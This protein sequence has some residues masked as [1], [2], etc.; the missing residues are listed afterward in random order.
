M[1]GNQVRFRIDIIELMRGFAAAAIVAFHY[2]DKFD[3]YFT[4]S[5]RELAW[6]GVDIF[7]VIS[8]FIIP[9]S[10]S[11]T[12]YSIARFWHFMGRRMIRLE[13]PYLAS[14]LLILML[15]VINMWVGLVPDADLPTWQQLLS[16]LLYLAPLFGHEWIN[17]VYWTLGCEFL[18]YLLVGLTY[19]HF[20]QSSVV[21]LL[22]FS[23]ACTFVV[24]LFYDKFNVIP[25][26]FLVGVLVYRIATGYGEVILTRLGIAASLLAIASFRVDLMVMVAVT[27]LAILKLRRVR[28]PCWMTIA[29]PLTYSLYLIHAP[30]GNGLLKVAG[31]FGS[32]IW[33]DILIAAATVILVTIITVF[34]YRIFEEPA[35]RASRKVPL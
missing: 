20:R 3:Y 1:T 18:F 35:I 27:A 33:F 17:P 16:H 34:Y 32:K 5:I 30:L 11:G 8:G 29:A 25:L 15:S 22:I 31:K 26:E 6:L 4:Q 21:H 7:F 2:S 19:G 13:P 28:L 9:Y 12:D 14:I 24:N 10:L 23:A